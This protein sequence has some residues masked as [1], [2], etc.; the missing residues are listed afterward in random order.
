[1]AK[2]PPP[3]AGESVV[4]VRRQRLGLAGEEGGY[5][6]KGRTAEERGFSL[7]EARVTEENGGFALGDMVAAPLIRRLT[8]EDDE[9]A[10]PCDAPIDLLRDKME[11]RPAPKAEAILALCSDRASLETTVVNRFMDL[12]VV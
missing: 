8:A 6:T 3:R 2:S 12:F 11:R 7:H 4:Q 10:V 9:D 5:R 1:M